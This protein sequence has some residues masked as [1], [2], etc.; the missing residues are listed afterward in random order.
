LAAPIAAQTV[1]GTVTNGVTHQPIVG[2][3]IAVMSQSGPGYSGNVRTDAAGAFSVNVKGPGDYMVLA[4]GQGYDG[5]GQRRTTVRVEPAKDPE[6][7]HL[8][9]TPWPN[10]SGRVVDRERHPVAKIQVTAIPMHGSAP[11]AI[12]DSEG[13]YSFQK[14]QPGWYRLLANPLEGGGHVDLAP[15]YYPDAGERM[16]SVRVAVS[17]GPDLQGYDIVLRDG[18]FFHVTGR[19]VD[20][21]GEPAAGA[22][23]RVRNADVLFALVTADAD[24]SFQIEKVP[25]MN[26]R[27]SAQWK[28]GQTDLQGYNGINVGGHDLE[29]VELRVAP[30]VSLAGTVEL[31]GKAFPP[32]N[33][34]AALEAA[35]GVALR[36]ESTVTERG[37]SFGDAYA[38][39]YKLVYYPGGQ[40]RTYVDSIL[41]GDRDITLQQFDLA[42]GMPPVRVILQSDGGRVQGTIEDSTE[43]VQTVLVPQD[44]RLRH[45][46]FIF[47]SMAANG[48]FQ[49]PD[50][51]PGDYFALTLRGL[52]WLVD[53]QDPDLVTPLLQRA[54]AVHVDRGAT[55]TVKLT[56]PND[57]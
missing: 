33:G 19:V 43:P 40:Q 48:R 10:L 32:G 6:P 34:Y 27:L 57:R 25:Q 29:N 4:D 52:V 54:T 16:Q 56:M 8:V 3:T 30:P 31:D 17:A 14:V 39:A 15:A 44:E 38:G 50:V 20:E 22:S 13:R 46:P 28:R 9:L 49:F 5:A 18:P 24:G 11:V 53:L 47:Q 55:A 51:R 35:D 41:L 21:H 12:T 7:L 45:L 23:V 37:F 36:I 1:T 42:P 2:V 26:G